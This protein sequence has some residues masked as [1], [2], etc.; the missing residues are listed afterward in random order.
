M[1]PRYVKDVTIHSIL[2]TEFYI[3]DIG[4]SHGLH[5]NM[6]VTL[7]STHVMNTIVFS[8]E[9]QLPTLYLE[10]CLLHLPQCKQMMLCTVSIWS[11]LHTI[12]KVSSNYC[13]PQVGLVQLPTLF[14]E[15][16]LFT[17]HTTMHKD[18]GSHHE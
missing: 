6:F 10:Q 18:D 13:I 15:Q 14:L 1:L 12:G 8:L 4:I 5:Q 16:Y 17:T 11:I 9:V 7:S 2:I 3:D